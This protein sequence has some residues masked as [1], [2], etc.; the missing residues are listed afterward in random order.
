MYKNKRLDIVIS[1]IDPDRTLRY[2]N[3]LKSAFPQA[4]EKYGQ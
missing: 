2:K 3:N 4:G 1:E